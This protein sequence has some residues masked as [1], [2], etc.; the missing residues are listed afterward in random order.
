MDRDDPEDATLFREDPAVGAMTD[1]ELLNAS[2]F[3]F[4][5]QGGIDLSFLYHCGRCFE[6]EIRY[7]AVDQ[8]HGSAM[9]NSDPANGFQIEGF[10]VAFDVGRNVAV[11]LESKL[12]SA[13][14]N[15]RRT[16]C[17]W[18]TLLG[19]FRY[20]EFKEDL[21]ATAY[22]PSTMERLT[23]DV[24][25][26]NKLYGFQ[27]GAE[28]TIVCRGPLSL[29]TIVKAGIYGVADG[30]QKT[31]IEEDAVA[32]RL[33]DQSTE[34]AF[35]GEAALTATYQPTH[36]MA[37]NAGY[38]T[39]W[40]EGIALATEQAAAADYVNGDGVDV[41]GGVFYHGAMVTLEFFR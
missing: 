34:T 6:L 31:A 37:V 29:Q 19:G 40:I 35:V 3:D 32:V 26:E 9:F 2:E 23:Y 12:Y 38:Q 25:T 7:Y 14:I 15:A 13:E 17:R 30:R 1:N 16:L 8:W 39:A 10:P 4:E 41:T 21:H 27:L 36:W 11:D 24:E 22:A 20:V 18:I 28:G 5:Y 33:R